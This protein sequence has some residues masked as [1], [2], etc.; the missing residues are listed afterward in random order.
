ML[1]KVIFTLLVISCVVLIPLIIAKENKKMIT[2]WAKLYGGSKYDYFLGICQDDDYIYGVGETESEGQGYAD[3]LIVKFNKSDLN[4]AAK[5]IYGGS[6]VDYFY[7]VCQDTNYVYAVGQT[8]SEGQGYSD[9]LIIKFNKSDLSIVAKKTYGGSGIELFY[10]VCQDND[11]VYAVGYT[12][13]EGQ[14]NADA[15]IVKFNKS[16][17][18]IAAKKIYGGSAN[19]AFYKVCQDTNYVYAV[20]DTDSE[21]QGNE[22]ALIVK[23]N[24]SDLSIAAKKI[25]GGSLDDNLYGVCQDNDYIYAVYY[26]E[27]E[28]QGD[29]DALIVKFNKSDLS[30]AAKKIYGGNTYDYFYGVC[31]DTNYVYA[32]GE[33]DSEGQG[34][35]DAMIVKFNKSDL[36]I[37][38]KKIYGGSKSDRFME[39]CQDTNY[40]YV[41][42]RTYS[43]AQ[44]YTDTLIVKFIKDIPSGSQDTTPTGFVY[45]DSNLTLAD[46]N[47]TLS[48]SNLTLADSNLT[49]SDSN[50]TLADSNLTLSVTYITGSINAPVADFSASPLSGKYPLTVQ[51]T[52][53]STNTPTSWLWD[54]GDGSTSTEQNPIH[55]YTSEG[56]FTVSLTATNAGGSDTKTKTNYITAI[57]RE[58]TSE[59]TLTRPRQLSAVRYLSSVRN[60]S[61]VRDPEPVRQL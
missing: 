9:A 46:S 43:E 2:S 24:K 35:Y 18:S 16:D 54:F 22:D 41:V 61:A 1:R 50:L 26:T 56:S 48:D 5:K 55:Q 19:E 6:E 17:L 12:E 38:A 28:G 42:G 10:G 58:V 53:L 21:G 47:L 23:F 4:V 49:L 31:Q 7:G 15:L 20:G 44:G 32:V 34:N 57:P 33:T 40:V 60:L 14:G 27:S 52:D 29:R 25:Y 59:R 51:F 8:E 45:Q 39:V 13:S 36:S 11:Y 37:A 3:A 30:I